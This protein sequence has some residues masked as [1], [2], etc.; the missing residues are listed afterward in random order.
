MGEHG[1]EAPRARAP[2]SATPC[3]KA[4]PSDPGPAG[5]DAALSG[6][7]RAIAGHTSTSSPTKAEPCALLG[8]LRQA[9]AVWGPAPAACSPRALVASGGP[10]T[11]AEGWRTHWFRLRA[12][13]LAMRGSGDPSRLVASEK[14]DRGLRSQQRWSVAGGRWGGAAE[15]SRSTGRGPACPGPRSPVPRWGESSVWSSDSQRP[16][17]QHCP[18]GRRR[19]P[20]PPT[21]ARG[22]AGSLHLQPG[23]ARAP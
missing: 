17:T 19:A 1:L 2:G 8:A 16:D 4:P 10:G 5:A 18:W 20:G 9:L 11:G 13:S 3:P 12:T 22:A 23:A 21:R 7:G 15:V 14:Q 6:S